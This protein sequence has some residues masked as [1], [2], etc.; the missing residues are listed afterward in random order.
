MCKIRETLRSAIF[1]L[2]PTS[3]TLIVDTFGTPALDVADEFHMSKYVFVGFA[4]PLALMLYLPILDKEVEREYVDEKELMSLPGCIPPVQP[5]D[6]LVSM[7]D[8]TNQEYKFLLQV[9]SK[10]CESDG[11]LTNTWEDLDATTLK[12]MRKEKSYGFVPVY[13][14]GPLIRSVVPLALRS[15]LLDWLEEQLVESVLWIKIPN[16]FSK[17]VSQ[18]F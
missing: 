1:A 12:A 6:V 9:T 15:Q 4:W 3:S 16:N 5:E 11:V 13:A 10:M 18:F 2:K 17:I 14:V 8:R 7:M